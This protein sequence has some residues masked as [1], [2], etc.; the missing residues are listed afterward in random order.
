MDSEY[1]D[2]KL[3]WVPFLKHLNETRALPHMHNPNEAAGSFISISKQGF[4]VL[5]TI[6]AIKRRCQSRILRLLQG[7]Q[8]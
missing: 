6:E 2:I 7:G 8:G 4:F 5:S 3:F 1:F